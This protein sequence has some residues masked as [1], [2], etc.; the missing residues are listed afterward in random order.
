MYRCIDF[1]GVAHNIKIM[2]LCFQQCNGECYA[3]RSV[4]E[5]YELLAGTHS[6]ILTHVHPLT[7]SLT[8]SLTH[9][10]THTHTHS[11][12]HTP[13]SFSPS[14]SLSTGDREVSVIRSCRCGGSGRCRR[15]R[16]TVV[17]YPV[18]PHSH[19]PILPYTHSSIHPYL[20]TQILPYSHFHYTYFN[21]YLNT[22][23]I[24]LQQVC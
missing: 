15:L 16:K 6:Y 11:H 17:Y 18:S 2:L 21:L 23:M 7:H 12:P 9:P 4:L 8:H 22:H 24:A 1:L 13:Y 19:T 3:K 14:L 10:Y 20:H 5:N